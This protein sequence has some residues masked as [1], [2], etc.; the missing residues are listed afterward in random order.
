MSQL[1]KEMFA[2]A[3]TSGRGLSVGTG[4]DPERM[5]WSE[6]HEQARR[7]AGALAARGIGPGSSVAVLAAGAAD[8]APLVQAIWMRRAT[9]TMLQQPTPRTDLLVWLEDTARAIALIGADVT[10]VGEPF[11]LALDHLGS[12][13]IAAI[14]VE[15]TRD[16]ESIEPLEA[17]EDDI[18]MR[19]LTSGSTGVPKAVEITHSNFAANSVAMIDALDIVID[20]DVSVSW[21]PLSHDMGMIAF[22]CVPMQLG[23][24]AVVVT[25]ESFLRRPILWAELM[26]R[27]KATI[28]S[29][30]NFAYSVLA[31]ILERADASAIDLSSM[32]V[33]VNGAEP[34][35][36]RDLANFAAVGAR[37]G[38]SPSVP[39]AGYGLAEATLA[40]SFG[41]PDDP[42]IVDAVSRDAV[43][44]R[45]TAEP[46]YGDAFSPTQR[47]VCV[48]F[49]VKGMD[50]RIAR[51]GTV[52]G[53]RGIGA[54]ELRGPAVASRYL[55]EDG[56]V[57]MKRQDGWFDT[58]D[59][60]YLDEQGR[61][62][63]CGRTKDLIVLA[64]K[65]LY[66]N[67]IER[68]TAMVDGVRKGCVIAVR[69]DG[70]EEREGFAVLA[71]AHGVDDAAVRERLTRE[72]VAKVNSHVGHSPR[73]V[74]L[75]P[76]GALPKTPSGKLRRNSAR[77]LLDR[78]PAAQP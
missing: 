26:S 22:M 54:I 33:A 38:L 73:E 23:V 60:G 31:R 71:E 18:A 17:E 20:Q 52:L 68:A 27:H 55:T 14:T 61:I 51:D 8:V 66:P 28:T 63:V 2:S 57:E 62:Y 19:Q 6:V 29:G 16:G 21:L 75:L 15:S 58:G 30:P 35:D 42:A 5:L 59:L 64:G 36:H 72:I 44:S 7:M 4:D 56:F 76:A 10:I 47:I 70:G 50:V 11:L 69:I 78:E 37:F 43:T 41:A 12:K 67:D 49:P 25:P 46:A 77:E 32:R 24:E 13:A 40:V 74:L 53:P 34:I 9:F 3:A 39:T 65:N 48:G 1:T 45:Q